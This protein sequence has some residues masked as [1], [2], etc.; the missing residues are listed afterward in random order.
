[1]NAQPIDDGG[2]SRGPGRPA[3]DKMDSLQKEIADKVAALLGQGIPVTHACALV[4][5]PTSTYYSWLDRFEAFKK[6]VDRARA[7]A[8]ASKLQIINNAI[9]AGDVETAKWFLTHCFPQDFARN[10]IEVTG[11]DGAP[12]AGAVI[13]LPE[14]DPELIAVNPLP[15]ALPDT[16]EANSNVT[17]ESEPTEN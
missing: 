11:P 3:Q 17:D 16:S 5:L 12:L 4:E 6:Q 9:Q 10:R 1:M 8:V 15:Q 13:V 2:A 14:K 7:Y